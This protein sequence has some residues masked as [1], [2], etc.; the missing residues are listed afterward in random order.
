MYQQIMNPDCEANIRWSD[1][2]MLAEALGGL[3]KQGK[4]SHVH[5]VLSN[6]GITEI[7]GLPN[8]HPRNQMRRGYI[9]DFRNKLKNLDFQLK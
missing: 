2:C 6:G 7:V 5:F 1:A 8:P 9:R 3:R 4:G